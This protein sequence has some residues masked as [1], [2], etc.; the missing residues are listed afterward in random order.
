MKRRLFIYLC[1]FLFV[2][3]VYAQEQVSSNSPPILSL[4][5]QIR[6][7]EVIP[8]VIIYQVQPG[9]TIQKIARK[10]QTTPELIK[11]RN[12]L[13]S[14]MI[15]AGQQ[16]TLWDRPF[17][18]EIDKTTNSLFLRIDHQVVKTYPVSTGKESS[19]TPVGE[20]VIKTRY[21]HPTWFHKG[22]VVPGGTPQNWLGTRWLGF[23]KPKYGIHG[24]IYPELIGQSVSGG[25][26]RMKNEDIEELYDLVPVGTKV[27]IK[28][29]DIVPGAE[30]AL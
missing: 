14:D 9:D 10:H 16:L 24:T 3:Q 11:K 5:D 4:L 30:D 19:V 22:E 23:D 15:R 27:V 25:C 17:N 1:F 6:S 12:H 8:G 20:F 28:E 2:T 29:D 21:P 7:D 18:I 13:T 26:I